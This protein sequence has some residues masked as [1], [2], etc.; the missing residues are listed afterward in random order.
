MLNKRIENAINVF[1]DALNNDTLKKGSCYK[2]AVGSLVRDGMLKD[3]NCVLIDEKIKV[4]IGDVDNADWLN[5][6]ITT[7]YGREIRATDERGVRKGLQAI[8]YTE[9][10]EEELSEIEHTFEKNAD[11]YTRAGMIQGLNAVV[12]LMLTFDDN[13]EDKVEEIFTKRAELIP[14]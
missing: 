2:C 6:F 4:K 9:F 8:S 14:V 5:L 1:L 3:P 10:T 13:K 12:K 7:P 11:N